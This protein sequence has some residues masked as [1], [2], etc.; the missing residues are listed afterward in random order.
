MGITDTGVDWD[1]PDLAADIWINWLE[2]INGNG[3][4]DTIPEAQGGD[5][6]NFDDDGNGYIDDVIGWDFVTLS[7]SQVCPGEDYTA[8]NDP[9]DFDGHGTHVS[10]I[11][12][13]V[14]NNG[15][16]VAGM[17]RDCRI[18]PLRVGWQAPDCQTGLINMSFAVSGIAYGIQKSVTAINMSY[19]TSG[20]VI[21]Q[22]MRDAYAAG[23]VMVHSAGNDNLN[24][25]DVVDIMADTVLSVAATNQQDVKA[26]FSNYGAWVDVSAPGVGIMSTF[27]NDGYAD[28][29]GTSMSAP[30]VTGLAGLIR[31]QS[32][33]LAVDEVIARIKDTAEDI[34]SLNP[35]YE[36][37]LGTG[38]INAYQALGSHLYSF[39]DT[40]V[41]WVDDSGAANPNDRAEV[42]ETVD[43]IVQLRNY[44]PWLDAA[45]IEGRL[46]T[47]D[48][49]ITIVDSVA[50]FPDIFAG[51]FGSNTSNPFQF[52][53]DGGEPRWVTFVLWKDADNPPPPNNRED[54]LSVLI[55]HPAILLV[56]DDGGDDAE[57]A[58]ED[59][60]G[61][62]FDMLYDIWDVAEQGSPDS[63]VPTAELVIWFTSD[64]SET[65]LTASDMALLSSFLDG[66]GKLFLSGTDIAEELSGET[67][68]SDYLH[69]SLVAPTNPDYGLFG[70]EGDPI[71]DSLLI[72]VDAQPGKDELGV[73]AGADSCFYYE[74]GG[75]AGL[76][77]DSGTYQVVFFGFGWEA[78]ND[79]P[80]SPTNDKWEVME[81]IL[82]WFGMP[83]HV[84][85]G[86]E[87]MLDIPSVLR[88]AQNRPN[89]VR[90]RT[91]I[92]YAVPAGAGEESR[93][94][95]ANLTV[96]NI[97]GQHVR[98][99]VDGP[100]LPGRHVVTW[101][102]RDGAGQRVASGVYFYRLQA[103]RTQ[104][105]RKMIVVN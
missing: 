82:Y 54:T 15:V 23:V 63:Y 11:A 1:P 101:D 76:H 20:G 92:T 75:V 60:L 88:L 14:T 35:G 97:L 41:Y 27:F 36:G 96:Y 48:P 31:S 73:L 70:V 64:D 78:I 3:Q 39:L 7:P 24:A 77:Y 90:E 53:V 44:Q 52:R 65:T 79:A 18:M 80:P 100:V 86:P 29:Q 46:R 17:A 12:A 47:D 62:T 94:V 50:T 61:D 66:G 57:V 51:W 42:G 33:G 102:R 16:G 13:A 21:M 8:D 103:G 81:R 38:R 98:T 37:M 34:D 30:F 85:S 9:M 26:G 4:F 91:L 59:V 67:F 10:G 69:A 74:L 45:N 89:P 95:A 105:T 5:I 99:L 49:D 68:L 22:A 2:D 28:L 72:V 87:P 84:G 71:G 43:F 55:D 40:E 25:P 32:P 83:P 93:T 104:A 58:Y 19:D 6:N 56:D